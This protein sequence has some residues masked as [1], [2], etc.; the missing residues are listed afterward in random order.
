[1]LA[2]AGYG[3]QEIERLVASGAAAVERKEVP[4]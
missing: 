2:E 4:A 3:P 1:V